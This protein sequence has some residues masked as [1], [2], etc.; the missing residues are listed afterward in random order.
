MCSSACTGVTIENLTIDGTNDISTTAPLNGILNK[1]AGQGSY[2]NNVTFNQILG[3]GLTI[4]GTSAQGSGP[5]SN[6]KFDDTKAQSQ[7]TTSCVE[8]ASDN[9]LGLHGITCLAND[10]NAPAGIYVDASHNTIED[11]T[12]QGFLDGIVIGQ[13]AVAQNDV[14]IGFTDTTSSSED[15]AAVELASNASNI[16]IL[17]VSNS[18]KKV[19][20]EDDV[21]GFNPTNT[22]SMAVY[23]LG[24]SESGGYSRLS[25][26]VG[27][28]SGAI[29][30]TNNPP[31]WA[32]GSAD[33]LL[34]KACAPGSLYSDTASASGFA[35]YVCSAATHFWVGVK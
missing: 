24:N 10:T 9:T 28:I 14:I 35:L 21:T 31:T 26:G 22:P 29:S 25:T 15:M 30:T 32:S 2:V 11:V 33:P 5:Y 23:V 7:S 13:N 8:L 27:V 19:I 6:L 3:V 4:S 34:N 17:G 1:F 12:V 18:S 20:V 16:V